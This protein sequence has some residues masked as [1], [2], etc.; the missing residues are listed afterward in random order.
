[1]IK[2]HNVSCRYPRCKTKAIDNI[3]LHVQKGECVVLSGG[4][5]C[6]KST[7]IKLLNGQIPNLQEADVTGEIYIEGQP[8]SD[9]KSWELTKY[10]GTV[11][12]NP[13][14]QFFTNNTKTELAF[15]MENLGWPREQIL[16]RLDTL[17]KE[18]DI[19]ALMNRHILHLSSGER[20]R[21]TIACAL[22]LSPQV[23]LFDEPSANL[24]YLTTIA[25]G[26][27]LKQ[28]KDKGHT[29]VIAEHRFFYLLPVCDRMFYI[30][31]G[32]LERIVPRSELRGFAREDLRRLTPFECPINN[33]KM[34]RGDE[35]CCV[36]DLTYKDILES[37]SIRVAKGEAIA[38]VGR[39]GAGKTTLA[40]LISG[41]LKPS[42]GCIQ[43]EDAMLV[44][45]DTDYQFF[46]ESVVNELKLGLINS[47]QDE[48]DRMIQKMG[49]QGLEKRHP[50]T[51]LSGGQKQ[52]VL[53]GAAG[54]SKARLIILDEPTSGLDAKNMQRVAML[55]QEIRK[56]A[57]VIVITH[58]FELIAAACSRLV[59]LENSK[60]KVDFD[61][62]ETTKM[63]AIEIFNEMEVHV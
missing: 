34:R 29:L 32:M 25:L 12:Q 2:M 41:I 46:T 47:S 22:T 48:I 49:L 50:I 39:N 60:I 33:V 35:V 7:L 26:V 23:L 20:Q 63:K 6:G 5:G 45:Q 15:A 58:D 4:S 53:L 37:I 28:L 61:L 36:N 56:E 27:L 21:I 11:N 52:R 14:S 24:D 38:L 3:N 42:S 8:L 10:V 16:C 40:K 59:W 30:K 54:L 13:R 17:I 31:K 44:M 43:A 9:K 19:A 55:I 18:T 51:A 1:M 57:G 62:S